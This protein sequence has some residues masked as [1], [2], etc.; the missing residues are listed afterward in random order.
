MGLPHSRR[1][2]QHEKKTRRRRR[3]RRSR[4]RMQRSGAVTTAPRAGCVQARHEQ[5][6]GRHLRV[7]L[8]EEQPPPAR[9]PPCRLQRRR[10]RP[11]PAR[12]QGKRQSRTHGTPEAEEATGMTACSL[13]RRARCP[14]GSCSTAR[15]SASSA[16]TWPQAARTATRYAGT[17][18]PRTSSPGP[19]SYAPAARRQHRMSCPR[20]FLA[21]SRSP[22]RALNILPSIYWQQTARENSR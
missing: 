22:D 17:P 13:R 11:R 18:T 21:M 7:G 16:A 10:R 14:S 1:T 5:A 4:V 2:E 20:R 9:P 3:R 19:A 15:A 8:D 6:D 12:Q